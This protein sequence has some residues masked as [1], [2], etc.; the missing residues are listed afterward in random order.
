MS[1]QTVYFLIRLLLRSS[2]I[3]LYTVCHSVYIFWRHYCIVKSNCFM[4]R[5]TKV[6]GLGVPIFRVFMVSLQGKVKLISMYLCKI[7]CDHTCQLLEIFLGG[8]ARGST[9]LTT[10]FDD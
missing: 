9:F 5:T 2:L 3:R 4:S 1:E 10:F 6:V 7:R 8:T